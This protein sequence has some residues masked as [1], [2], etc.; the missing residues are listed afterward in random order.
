MEVLSVVRVNMTDGL[1]PLGFQS[2]DFP[3]RLSR[4][5]FCETN[6]KALPDDLDSKWPL[7]AGFYMENNKLTEIPRV[8]ARLKPLYLMAG[9]NPI[10]RLP[11]EL[12]EAVLGYFTLGGTK[13]TELP[14]YVA[15]PS[16]ALSHFDVTDTGIS[17]FWSWMDPLVED[18]FGVAPLVAAGGTP[19]CYELESIMSGSSSEFSAPFQIGHSSLLMNASTENWDTLV[20]AVDCSPSYGLTLFPLEYWDARYGLSGSDL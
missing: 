6:L 4:I 20:Q 2:P 18:M 8:L 19:Y 9:G 14:Q 3:S 11:S 5:S 16:T 10:T 17:F 12:F 1:L 15:E 13:L 7:R